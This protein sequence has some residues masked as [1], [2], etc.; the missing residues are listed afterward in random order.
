MWKSVIETLC[1]CFN[2]LT[3]NFVVCFF[4]TLLKYMYNV[5]CLN[6]YLFSEFPTVEPTSKILCLINFSVPIWSDILKQQFAWTGLKLHSQLYHYIYQAIQNSICL[7]PPV[8]AKYC[9]F[10]LFIFV[11][12]TKLLC[13]L[14]FF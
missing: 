3:L 9:W 10:E 2:F 13:I 11:S 5:L 8:C 4:T 14:K 12:K 1:K 7:S 6:I